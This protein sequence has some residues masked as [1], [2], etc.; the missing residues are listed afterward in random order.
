MQYDLISN[1]TSNNTKGSAILG[2]FSD[3]SIENSTKCLGA[4]DISKIKEIIKTSSFIGNLNQSLCIYDI[5]NKKI[6][7]IYLIGL[8]KKE[9]YGEKNLLSL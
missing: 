6:E 3:K 4:S 2:V 8:G 7:K 1:I 9:E 5:P